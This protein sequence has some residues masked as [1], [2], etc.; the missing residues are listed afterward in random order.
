[1]GD[2]YRDSDNILATIADRVLPRSL[3]QFEQYGFED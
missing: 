3:D 1:M 2:F